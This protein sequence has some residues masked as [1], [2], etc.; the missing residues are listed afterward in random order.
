MNAKSILI[1]CAILA[2]L[3]P[4]SASAQSHAILLQLQSGSPPADRLA[5]DSAGGLVASG[6][7]NAGAIPAEG[8]GVRMM[9][10][11]GRWAFR[12]GRVVDAGSTNW[13]LNNIGLGSAAFG[14]NTQASG[15]YSLAAGDRTI[16]SGLNSVA[17]GDRAEATGHD[18]FAVSMG[19]SATARG[20]IAI[21]SLARAHDAHAVALGAGNQASGFSATSIGNHNNATATGAVAIGVNNEASGARS[22]AIGS[23][24]VASAAYG[25]AIG[26]LA[27]TGNHKGSIV[28]SAGSDFTQDTVYASENYQIVMRAAGGMKFYTAMNTYGRPLPG[29][30]LAPGGNSWS[31][32][33]DV[34]RKENFEA[35]DGE[36]VLVRLREVPVMTWNYLSQ[37]ASIR[38]AGPTAQDFHA[39]FGLG[40]SELLINTIDIDG[41]N[42]AAIKALDERTRELD[43]AR[44][45]IDALRSEL[46][47]Q[48]LR[49]ELL[50]RRQ[51]EILE[52][53][54]R[55]ENRR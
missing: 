13:D 51:Q 49:I 54:D 10:F 16:A 42:L 52:R 4:A 45:E 48:K 23:N 25:M 12:A 1:A 37:D 40:E 47:A 29:V 38:H 32:V 11:P 3:L 30:E 8:A 17:F 27:S 55:I 39:A 6:T 36:D 35:L 14:E 15:R 2:I 18:S 28:I 22:T 33:S 21:G 46:A 7:A 44:A 41:I 19:A 43:G 5:V 20:A 31:A 50:E 26:T 9:W 24:N 34:N 53:L